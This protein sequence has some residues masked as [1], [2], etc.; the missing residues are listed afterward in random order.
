MCHDTELKTWKYEV[1][2][3]SYQPLPYLMNFWAKTNV[4][5]GLERRKVLCAISGDRLTAA[6]DFDAGRTASHTPSQEGRRFLL[7]RAAADW[8]AVASLD[9]SGAYMRAPRDPRFRV[10]MR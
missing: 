3:K 8:Y 5:G 4:I 6:L 2:Q 10:T 9:V 7:A 1:Q